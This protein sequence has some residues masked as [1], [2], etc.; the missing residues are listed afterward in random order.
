LLVQYIGGDPG[1][2]GLPLTDGDGSQ[3][4]NQFTTGF[5]SALAKNSLASANYNINL[6]ATGFSPYVINAGTRLIKRTDAGGSWLLNGT[7]SDAVGSVVK[8]TGMNGI[9][10][11]GGGTQFGI[12][13]HVQK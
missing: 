10:N 8:R 3:I 2:S 11:L 7:H 5:W 4:T 9:Y 6:D 1:N 12:G 13:R